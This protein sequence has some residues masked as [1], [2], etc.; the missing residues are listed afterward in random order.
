MSALFFYCQ[1]VRGISALVIIHDPTRC[2]L[3]SPTR[4]P[5]LFSMRPMRKALHAKPAGSANTKVRMLLNSA[6]PRSR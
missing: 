5:L 1:S 2:Y 6:T 4:A 3:D